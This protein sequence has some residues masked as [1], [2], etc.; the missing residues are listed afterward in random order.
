MPDRD[1]QAKT[2]AAWSP[3]VNHPESKPSPESTPP[4]RESESAH[5]DSGHATENIIASLQPAQLTVVVPTYNEASNLEGLVEA[6]FALPLA[7]LRVVI[8]D[9]NSPDGTGPLAD[10]LARR[11]NDPQHRITVIHRLHKAGLGTAYI[12]GFRRAL[13][14]GAE[15]VM[16]MDA[17]FSHNPAYIIP[18][19]GVINATGADV[20]VGSR[21]VTG[22]TLD[23]DWSLLRRLLSWWANLYCRA[24]LRIRVRDMTAGF[25]L[26]RR[27]ALHE[28][29][30][31]TVRSNGY[32]FTVEMAYL[33]EKLGFRIIELPIHFEDRRIGQSKMNT[34]VKFESAWRVWELLWRHRSRLSQRTGARQNYPLSI[35]P[36]QSADQPPKVPTDAPT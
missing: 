1:T 36:V 14:D 6:L 24:I 34:R 11:Y 4:R 32:I 9:D 35:P 7:N 18:M 15:F 12:E 22:G 27:T 17:D 10:K 2:V 13:S 28:L 20:I 19:L 25:K 33:S 5:P 26:W 3:K 31:D 21:Y 30:L 16:Q 29:G 23:R 8:V